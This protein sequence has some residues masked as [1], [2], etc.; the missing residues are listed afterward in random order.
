MALD[1]QEIIR[2]VLTNALQGGGQ[3]SNGSSERSSSNGGLSGMKGLAAGAGAAALA[4]IALKNAGKLTKLLGVE[5]LGDVVKSP[6]EALSGA[7]SNV[8]ERLTS[9]AKEKAK[10]A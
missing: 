7:A 9:G 2:E 6:G 4:P 5:S 10:D 3:S 8:G 1:M